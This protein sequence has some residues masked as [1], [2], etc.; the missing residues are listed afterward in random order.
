VGNG[1]LKFSAI[2]NE[3]GRGREIKEQVTV[4]DCAGESTLFYFFEGVLGVSSIK[5]DEG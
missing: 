3:F 5:D 2:A 4:K 1:H